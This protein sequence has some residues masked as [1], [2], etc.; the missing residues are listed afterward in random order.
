MTQITIDFQEGFLHDKAAVYVNG[1]TAATIADVTTKNQIGLAERV[2]LEAPPGEADLKVEL[3]NRNI[4]LQQKI[5]TGSNIFVGVSL[6]GDKLR[7]NIQS[8]EFWYA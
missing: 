2:Q 3:P 6:T 7:F 1:E 5:P 4:S 8:R